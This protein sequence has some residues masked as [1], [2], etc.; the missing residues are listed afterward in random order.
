LWQA[1]FLDEYAINLH[2]CDL[3][4]VAFGWGKSL[5]LTF[6]DGALDRHFQVRFLGLKR[7]SAVYVDREFPTD[8]EWLVG[9]AEVSAD[10][11]A[12]LT[13]N[14]ELEFEAAQQLFRISG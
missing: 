4:E 8:A 12:V 2:D 5:T 11:Y 9:S 7:L 6:R 14:V 13:T 10:V 1:P 3:V